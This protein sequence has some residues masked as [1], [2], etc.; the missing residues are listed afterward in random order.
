MATSEGKTLEDISLT[1]QQVK[2]LAAMFKGK[3]SA[4]IDLAKILSNIGDGAVQKLA[5]AAARRA[6][7][8]DIECTIIV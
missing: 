7:A 8:S 5:E 2:E 4:V 3:A 6:S 1:V